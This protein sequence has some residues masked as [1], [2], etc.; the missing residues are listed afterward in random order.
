MGRL[1]NVLNKRSFKPSASKAVYGDGCKDVCDLAPG[2]QR[3][4]I[5]DHR[6]GGMGEVSVRAEEVLECQ[7]DRAKCLLLPLSAPWAGVQG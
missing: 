1:A 3:S 6:N 2:R 5:S 4:Y 7:A